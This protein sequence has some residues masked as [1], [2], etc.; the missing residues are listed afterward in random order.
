VVAVA[1]I[2]PLLLRARRRRAWQDELAA[3]ERE[4]AWLARFLVPEMRRVAS[5]D[6]AVGAWTVEASRVSALED[7][8]TELAAT[9]RDDAGRS[10]AL[11]LRDAVRTAS[12]RLNVLVRARQFEAL[13]YDLDAVAAELE[14]ALAEGAGDP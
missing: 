11:G 14:A 8:L 12:G 13:A 4:I 5:P 9:A 1:V 2:V 6:E 10:R 7:R 3:A